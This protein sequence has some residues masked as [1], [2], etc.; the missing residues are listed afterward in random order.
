MPSQQH[1]VFTDPF[2]AS[3]ASNPRRVS[4]SALTDYAIQQDLAK[5]FAKYSMCPPSSSNA[6]TALQPPTPNEDDDKAGHPLLR[7]QQ[8]YN[9][10]SEFPFPSVDQIAPCSVNQKLNEVL[11]KDA[12]V[13]YAHKISLTIQTPAKPYTTSF[14]H[15][16]DTPPLTPPGLSSPAESYRDLPT[17]IDGKSFFAS[18]TSLLTPE[19][20]ND[21]LS[22]EEEE[23]VEQPTVSQ[24]LLSQRV[25]LPAFASQYTILSEL[26][27]GGF[28]FVV[29]GYRNRDSRD[30]A[31]KFIYKQSM[32]AH[33]WVRDITWSR[34]TRSMPSE[35][36]M[37][38][39]IK[40]DGVV[41]FLDLFEDEDY[42]YM[43]CPTL[44]F[45][46]E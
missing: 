11:E 36:Q 41:A 4:A 38:M 27:T 5:A 20:E 45:F 23:Q 1:I 39:R 30:V 16:P 34:G 10:R 7:L 44:F 22:P 9:E 15:S 28:G 21:L 19:P 2:L 31:I 32:P 42:F 26:G 3:Y 24:Q 40:H 29:R 13:S 8:S 17:P 14:A 18:P 46:Q 25:L 35:A 33:A 6:Y 43:V 12:T 37:L